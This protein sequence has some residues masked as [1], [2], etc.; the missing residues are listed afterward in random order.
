M[1]EVESRIGAHSVD[2]VLAEFDRLKEHF[3][4]LNEATKQL[5]ETI[6]KEEGIT[7]HSVQAR[8]KSRDKLQSKYCKPDRD[9][10]CLSDISDIVGLRI[11]TFY[12]D[13]LDQIADII[14]REF[15]Q[16]GPLEDKRIGK[17]DTFGYSAI[18]MDCAYTPEQLA[19]TEY[20][21]FANTRFEIQITTI[22]GH[23]WAEMH[24]PWY[25]ESDSPNDEVRRFHRLAAVLELAEQEFL[26][27]RKKKDDRERIASVRVAAEAPKIPI[28]ADSLTAFI[29]QK[30]VVATVD[31]ELATIL[32]RTVGNVGT[33]SQIA[34]LARIVT[35]AGIETTQELEEMLTKA[36]PAVAEYVRLCLPIWRKAQGQLSDVFT[37]GFSIFH[38]GNLLVGALGEEKYGVFLES[39]GRVPHPFLD[40]REQVAIAKEVAQK[41]N[42]LR[43][44]P[45]Q[46]T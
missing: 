24:H 27:I 7:I 11:I 14:G 17:P 9:Y 8:V 34:H 44:K 12:S 20:R 23:A 29:E 16:R 2:K 36:A 43:D 40:V 32:G 33:Q 18:H 41:Y 39:V 22:I 13:K 37:H 25:D 4:D 38:L 19:R 26:E 3:E 6:L 5:I 21:R 42:I 10:K 31:G 45:P 46:Q 35:S 15:A 28:T 30:D 1:P